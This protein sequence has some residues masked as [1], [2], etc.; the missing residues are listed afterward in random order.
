MAMSFTRWLLLFL[1]GLIQR[2]QYDVI[3]Y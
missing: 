3:S 1:A 2:W